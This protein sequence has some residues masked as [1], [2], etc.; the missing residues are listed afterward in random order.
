MDLFLEA[1]NIQLVIAAD[2]GL[3]SVATVVSRVGGVWIPRLSPQ[4]R[5][6]LGMIGVMNRNTQG[7]TIQSF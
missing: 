6:R 4:I 2:G 3:S 7:K 5:S 1:T